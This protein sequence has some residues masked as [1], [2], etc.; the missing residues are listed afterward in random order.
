MLPEELLTFSPTDYPACCWRMA[1]RECGYSDL[2]AGVRSHAST[3]TDEKFKCT[4]HP[5]SNKF[6]QQS[7][8]GA[9]SKRI[10][11]ASGKYVVRSI[12]CRI[13][14]RNTMTGIEI[15]RPAP[16]RLGHFVLL[17]VSNVQ[18]AQQVMMIKV[19][20]TPSTHVCLARSLS[21]HKGPCAQPLDRVPCR[22]WIIECNTQQPI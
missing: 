17:V 20:M 10:S 21:S 19:H 4:S 5:I 2:F 18:S 6:F 1:H 16:S 15:R 7:P 22:G 14:R 3:I 9:H 13:G 11:D 8:L 12:S